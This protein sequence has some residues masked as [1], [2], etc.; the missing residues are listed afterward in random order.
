MK[1]NDISPSLFPLLH[2]RPELLA[3]MHFLEPEKFDLSEGHFDLEDDEKEGKI[4]DLHNKLQSIMLRRLKKD[5]VTSLPTKSEKILRVEMSELQMFWY[6]AILSKNYAL[7]ASNNSQ[8]SL[9]NIAM[10][11]KKA[12]NHP[13]LFPGAEQPA[14]SKEATL[15]GLV[16]NSGKMILLD[17]LLT[18]LK[19]EGHRVLI[20]SQMVRMLD[21]MSDYMTMRGYI[22]QRL[23]GTVVSE[24]RRKAIGHFNA[25]DSPDFA[26]LLS[27]RAGGLGINLETADTVIIFDSDWN[28]QNDLQAMARAHR[29]GQKNHVNV[30][31]LVTKDTVEENV[32]ERAKR[33]MILEYAIINQMDT[34]GKHVGRREVPKTEQTFNKDDLSAILKFGA[35]NLF[36]S[37]ADQ[38]RLESMDLDEIMN[39][40]EHFET[41]T[42][43]S[44]TSL[45]GEDFL[46]QFAAV[47]DVKADMT[48]WD[49]IIPLSER[50]RMGNDGI[51]NS[52]HSAGR[53]LPLNADLEEDALIDKHV[54]DMCESGAEE[55]SERLRQGRKKT[56]N[57]SGLRYKDVSPETGGHR[58]KKSLSLKDIRNIIRSIQHFGDIDQRYDTI[59]KYAKVE[60]KDP[61]V[62]RAFI[63][64]LT[65]LCESALAENERSIALKRQA[66][67]EITPAI[68]NKAVLVECRKAA[69]INA[70]TVVN[71]VKDLKL[72]HDELAS[73]REPLNWTHPASGIKASTT[74]GWTCEWTEAKDN[75]LLIG[76]WRHGF[77]RWELIRDDPQLGL[78]DSIYLDDP[79]KSKTEDQKPKS[80]PSGVHLG[81]RCEYLLRAL[82]EYHEQQSLAGGD[83]GEHI[84]QDLYSGMSYSNSNHMIESR[85]RQ[86]AP[87]GSP[88][89]RHRLLV[90][91]PQPARESKAPTPK[92]HGS[93]EP[94]QLVSCSSSDLTEDEDEDSMDE[95]ECKEAMRPVKKELKELRADESKGWDASSR[96]AVLRHLLFVIG[97]HIDRCVENVGD[98]DRVR[99]RLKRH[100]WSFAVE[101]WPRP[102]GIEAEKLESMYMR[103]RS[104]PKTHR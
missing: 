69:N 31:R 78:S 70:D 97:S 30:Y 57:K 64:E 22:F 93:T 74:S 60:A 12:S 104:E 50:Q 36:R 43:P 28:P 8:V 56:K 77:G 27:T 80:T 98:D 90:K 46:Q 16:I 2:H 81:R 79:K 54:S 92:F 19:A 83:S 75:A 49:E 91:P 99:T 14:A 58:Q 37:S 39:K 13:F 18:R 84:G 25:P 23:D 10:E 76:V 6:K 3:L 88:V 59:V 65:A 34:S 1:T 9:L 73:V 47:Q 95:G 89:K 72:L 45:G 35:A 15:K 82:R 94:Q 33:K 11:L 7:L 52:L 17:K 102:E 32:L 62:V 24:E 4:K 61:A 85:T 96:A 63:E 21:I 38:N 44:G 71:R 66:G 42:A 55:T 40:G 20:F 101:W 103:V 5:V 68:R 53:H 67:E 41:E 86:S 29:I 26:F 100:L 48:S 51:T 87:E